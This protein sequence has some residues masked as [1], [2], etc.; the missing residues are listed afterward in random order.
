MSSIYDF[1][2]I[3]AKASGMLSKTYIGK[4]SRELAYISDPFQL[5]SLITD[6]KIT[7]VPNE[8]NAYKL[9]LSARKRCIDR[10]LLIIKS[11][12]EKDTVLHETLKIYDYLTIKNILALKRM[13]EKIQIIELPYSHLKLTAFPDL[14]KMFLNT[15][16][17]WLLEQNANLEKSKENIQ[18]LD[19]LIDKK[20]YVD[21]WAASNKINPNKAQHIKKMIRLEALIQNITW[22]LRL[23]FYYKYPKEKVLEQLIQLDGVDIISDALR[24]FDFSFDELTK[25]KDWKYYHLIK[26]SLKNDAH[27]INPKLVEHEAM[28]FLYKEVRKTF[29]KDPFSLTTAYC[30]L[31]LQRFEADQFK[32]AIEGIYLHL[33]ESQI[34]SYLLERQ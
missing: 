18:L 8:L 11:L 2:Y 21:L 10:S 23:A 27:T 14:N 1:S 7:S 4:K 3:Y 12:H 17:S 24:I 15:D 16:Y 31:R 28:R 33:S 6:N 20:Y 30:F 19:S 25:W 26:S 32:T 29:H 9:E 22:A 13:N 5:H 34:E